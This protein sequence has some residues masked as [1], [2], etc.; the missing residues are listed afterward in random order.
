M[1]KSC[2]AIGA[3]SG[4]GFVRRSRSGRPDLGLQNSSFAD[5]KTDSQSVGFRLNGTH[6]GLAKLH[7]THSQDE[8]GPE[9]GFRSLSNLF[10]LNNMAERVGLDF[11]HLAQ[12]VVTTRHK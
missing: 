7:A 6:L 10:I 3:T 1:S 4:V 2:V 5:R 12:V 9:I 11:R 8:R